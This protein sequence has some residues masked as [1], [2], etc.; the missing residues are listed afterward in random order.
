MRVEMTEVYLEWINGLKDRTVRA[1]VQVRV[2]RLVHGNPGQHRILTDG[3]RELKIDLGPGYRVYYTERRGVLI[4]LLA[5]GEKSSQASD[6][7]TAIALARN[8]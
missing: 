3:V 1:R 8:L 2:E 5:G 4:I 7:R 6:I